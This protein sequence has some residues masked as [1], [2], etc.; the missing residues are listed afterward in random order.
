M[1]HKPSNL[2]ITWILLSSDMR[3]FVRSRLSAFKY[4]PDKQAEVC[5]YILTVGTR[6]GECSQ[7]N[8]E[9][10]KQYITYTTVLRLLLGSLD[11]RGT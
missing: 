4:Y 6:L 8:S 10:G 5:K 2:Y 3:Q 9:L 1:F 7:N 11:I